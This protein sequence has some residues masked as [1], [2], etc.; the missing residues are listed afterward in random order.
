MKILHLSTYDTGGAYTAAQRINHALQKHGLDS[1]HLVGLKN[2]ASS[3]VIPFLKPEPEGLNKLKQKGIRIA[4]E[5]KIA[6]KSNRLNHDFLKN[7][8]KGFE[9]FT[10]PFSN[11]NPENHPLVKKADIIH[12]HW[13]AEFVDYE[14]FFKNIDKPIVWTI[15]DMNSFTGGCHYSM[16]CEQYNQA[17][18][19]CP[20]LAMPNV[21]PNFLSLKIKGIS[22]AK[23]LHFVGPSK[24]L[25]N[26]S[27]SSK[28]ASRFQHH[29]IKNPCDSNV[30]KPINK[31]ACKEVLGFPKDKIL[32]TYITP[33]IENKRKGFDFL[34]DL[35]KAFNNNDRLHFCCVGNTSETLPVH[36]FGHVTD[37]ILMA[38]IYNATDLFLM[39]SLA[40]NL[41]NVL[42]ES[43]L[44]GT[45]ALSFNVGGIPEII[46]HGQN[47]IL[48][49][50]SIE[51]LIAELNN[52]LNQKYLFDTLK[53]SS[54]ANLEYDMKKIAIQYETLYQEIII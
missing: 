46:K 21:A 31:V 53:I 35:I 32:I 16:D 4:N 42:I 29:H 7:K 47:G 9:M 40:D 12:L 41:P 10:S 18:S 20:Q 2:N 33:N 23:K 22:Q 38:Q 24:W 34:V 25:M 13:V 50:I 44:C 30:F 6:K 14:N 45:P 49:D 48:C 52:F 17:C 51:S 8:P 3:A 26:I 27:K 19:A 1:T 43:I 5:L 36:N 54:E 11:L 37:E 39:P 28:V 15:H